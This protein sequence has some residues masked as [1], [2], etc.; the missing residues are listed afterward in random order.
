MD[1]CPQS[2][3][4]K[5]RKRGHEGFEHRKS[6]SARAIDILVR[7]FQL[8]REGRPCPEASKLLAPT[9][10]PIDAAVLLAGTA[11]SGHAREGE[12]GTLHLCQELLERVKVLGTE[13]RVHGGAGGKGQFARQRAE[14]RRRRSNVLS[15]NT[16]EKAR[17]TSSRLCLYARKLLLTI[18]VG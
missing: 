17:R 11:D 15:A 5:R 7:T 18:S 6:L 2:P 9:S 16:P 1:E 3:P 13:M 4:K 10:T 12:P 14:T 8:S